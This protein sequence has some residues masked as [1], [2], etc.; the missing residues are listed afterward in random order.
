MYKLSKFILVAATGVL[1]K[2]LYYRRPYS[3]PDRASNSK[4][5]RGRLYTVIRAF[6]SRKRDYYVE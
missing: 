1:Y 5:V 2:L 3:T 4:V 6:W